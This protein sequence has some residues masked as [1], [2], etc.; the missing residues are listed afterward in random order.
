[1]EDWLRF[2][3]SATSVHAKS[4]LTSYILELCAAPNTHAPVVP[5]FVRSKLP[6][7]VK[8]L[9]GSENLEWRDEE[10]ANPS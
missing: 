7:W 2:L 8:I 5:E 6:S 1:M 4:V 3:L 9:G 10:R